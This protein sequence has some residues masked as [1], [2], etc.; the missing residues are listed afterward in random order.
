MFW[1]FLDRRKLVIFFIWFRKKLS[2]KHH[3]LCHPS[4]E[5]W[6]LKKYSIKRN[7]VFSI[8]HIVTAI[9]IS[10][11]TKHKKHTSRVNKT[12]FTWHFLLWIVAIMIENGSI[13]SVSFGF[14]TLILVECQTKHQHTARFMCHQRVQKNNI[15]VFFFPIIAHMTKNVL[16]KI[17][18][19]RNHF[20]FSE[21][22]FMGF[23]NY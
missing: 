21:Q 6:N 9:D 8:S 10:A 3:S 11:L 22:S 13:Q 20:F 23:F 18:K 12:F 7:W 14:Q 16:Y 5:E 15:F 1:I 4:W 2:R 19:N 17:P